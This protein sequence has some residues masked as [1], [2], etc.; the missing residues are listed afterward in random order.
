MSVLNFASWSQPATAAADADVDPA[1]SQPDNPA[2]PPARRALAPVA[3][4][5]DDVSGGKQE[6]GPTTV[7]EML[8]PEGVVGLEAGQISGRFPVPGSTGSEAVNLAAV[9]FNSTDLPWRF[10]PARAG[11]AQRLRPWLVLVVVPANI[12]IMPAAPLAT[13]TVPVRHLPDLAE[14]WAW[15]H[16]QLDGTGR[17]RLLCP[18]KLPPDSTLRAVVVP[19]FRGGVQ[20][21]LNQPVVAATVHTPAWLPG[22]PDDAVLP[23]YDW[24]EF[25]TGKDEDF[26]F[27]ARRI[28]PAPREMLGDFGYR[29]VDISNPW[30]GEE[31]V[32]TGSAVVSVGG[33]LRP[34]GPAPAPLPPE[35]VSAF[36]TR[37]ADAVQATADGD[38]GPP[39]RGGRHARRTE[40]VT[41]G[42]DWLDDANRDPAHRMAGARGSDWVIANQEQLMAEAWTQAGQIREAAR[43]LA[44]SRAAVAITESLQSRHLDNLTTDELLTV[45]A[46]AA[47][48]ARLGGAVDQPTVQAALG[49]SVAPTGVHSTTL[50]RLIRPAGVVGRATRATTLV[51]RATAGEITQTVT[52]GYSTSKL[53]TIAT[54]KPPAAE[55]NDVVT[56]RLNTAT[57]DTT[58]AAATSMWVATKVAQNQG[59]ALSA[60][61]T[62]VIGATN[63]LA[64]PSSLHTTLASRD[65]RTKLALAITRDQLVSSATASAVAVNPDGVRISAGALS[66][67][68]RG[69][70]DAVAAVRRRLASNIIRAD[71]PMP[72]LDPVLPT[73]EVPV[74]MSTAMLE[75][76]PEW[77]LPGI[78][79][80][81]MDRANL[82]TT[83]DAFVESVLLGAN[84]ELLGEFLWRE[85][86]TDRRGT[87]IGRFWPRPDGGADIKPIHQWSGPLGSHTTA[88]SQSNT[89]II[90]I[91]A[92]LF[93]RYPNTV[94]LAARAELD[95]TNPD[96][97]RPA[98]SLDNWLKPVFTLVIDP[99]TRVI[100]F[101]VPSTEVQ[102][103]LTALAPGWFFVMVE[104][105]TSI[106]FGFDLRTEPPTAAPPPP[107]PGDWNDLT[108]DH[109]IDERGFA[110]ARRPVSVQ[111]PPPSGQVWG[112]S[113]ACAADVARIALQ[114]PVR[115]ALHA[116]TM[117]P[118]AGMV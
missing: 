39:L 86:P 111:N 106:R 65:V 33:A 19:A 94:V 54:A 42:G 109:V 69:S 9:E 49:I 32:P 104:P 56:A 62:T 114:R 46:P 88:V 89:T 117:I 7:I 84:T 13:M 102:Q 40:I 35:Q 107:T 71:S 103:P 28:Q 26:E 3:L 20:A 96:H 105:P 14:S 51:S 101:P 93:R 85:F 76:D 108:W 18:R 66:S 12:A 27:L 17:S 55:L 36:A 37:I 87:P 8:G 83:D 60:S 41:A 6:A 57:I 64:G 25:S 29:R 47:A 97:V 59:V 99:S 67:L 1:D 5:Q 58:A 11:D 72:D 91:R 73:P 78:G 24:W 79:G 82:L 45:S 100:A 68:L 21:G 74:P 22:Q 115:V 81:P 4:V 70:F 77:F 92:E 30:P 63:L 80:F 95:P 90:L 10:S 75:R 110:T 50:A 98:G 44:L 61:F 113:A 43:R 48:R 118:G 52:T 23:V 38:L 31:P 53:A 16:V 34:L 116:A 2:D 15:A 112:G